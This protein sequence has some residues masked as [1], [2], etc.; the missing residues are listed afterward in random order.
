MIEI[1]EANSPLFK[2]DPVRGQLSGEFRT[3]GNKKSFVLDKNRAVVCVAFTNEVATTIEELD[4]AGDQVAMF[5]TVWSYDK[6]A[7]REIIFETGK[8]ISENMPNVRRFVT[9]SPQTNMAYRFHT[10]NG[11]EIIS[12][13][14][15]SINYE[16]RVMF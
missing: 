4:N 1:L 7:G 9:L 10:R 12:V 11:A 8:W 5:Y 6:G 14:D 2:D 16:Y 13:N 15:T 3:T